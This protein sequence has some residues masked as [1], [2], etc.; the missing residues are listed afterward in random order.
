MPEPSITIKP[1]PDPKKGKGYIAINGNR[2][3]IERLKKIVNKYIDPR[4]KE[5]IQD[6]GK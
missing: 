2:Q 5:K 4:I 1:N 3:D 6:I